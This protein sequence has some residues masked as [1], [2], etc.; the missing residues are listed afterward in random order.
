MGAGQTALAEAVARRISSLTGL[1]F[2]GPRGPRQLELVEAELVSS[3]GDGADRPAEAALPPETVQ[4]ICEALSVQE[5][6][7]YRERAALDWLAR[8]VLPTLRERGRS[9]SVW[10]AGCAEGQEAYTLA[11]VLDAAGLR[12]RHQ[13]LGTDLSA[14]AVASARRGTYG[15]WSLRGLD[16]VEVRRLLREEAGH[17]TVRDR[18][19]QGLT[20]ARHNLLDPPPRVRG[21]YDLVLCRNVLIYLTP[22][23]QHRAGMRLVEALAPGG[24]LLT[25]AADP[26]LDR[27]P[28]LV[29]VPTGHG[30]VYRRRVSSV[31][32]EDGLHEPGGCLVVRRSD[33]RA[34][35]AATRRRRGAPD[36]VE[37][38]GGGLLCAAEA[39]LEAAR[40]GRAERLARQALEQREDDGRAHVVLVQALAQAGRTADAVRASGQAVARRPLDAVLWHLHAVVLLDSGD[41]GSAA[42]AAERAATLNPGLAQAHLT[43]A[44]TRSAL[45]DR[46]G[47]LRARAI[48]RRLLGE[49]AVAR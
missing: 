14:S 19:R 15:P 3:L 33:G 48:G 18:F 28:G 22:S 39:A 37:P 1:S 38:S 29:P 46:V 47:A 2:E 16:D 42:A 23:A 24:W 31:G 49:G 7:F 20:F 36:S 35:G 5:S 21:G 11:A 25:G 12:G 40:S 13:V 30:P 4:R 26:L 43:L 9:V 32:E 34:T 44:R 6:F 17:F 27:V 41:P 45:G 10:S 8:S